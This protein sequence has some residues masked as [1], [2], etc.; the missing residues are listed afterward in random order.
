MTANEL[1]T[2]FGE[3]IRELR[4][5]RGYSQED[6]AFLCGIDRTYISGLERGKRNP[7]LKILALIAEKLDVGLGE[8]FERVEKRRK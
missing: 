3:V 1:F 6:F 2:D 4:K 5:Q 8:M 7:T